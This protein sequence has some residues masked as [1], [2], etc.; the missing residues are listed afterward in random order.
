MNV[1]AGRA[2][3]YSGFAE[4]RSRSKNFLGDYK[5]KILPSQLTG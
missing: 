5:T 1:V 4:T 3:L 2:K